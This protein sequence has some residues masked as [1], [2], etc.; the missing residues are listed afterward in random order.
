MSTTLL[1][2]PAA[3]MENRHGGW[4][5]NVY[6]WKQLEEIDKYLDCDFLCLFPD[7]LERNE[8]TLAFPGKRVLGISV[9]SASPLDIIR[10]IFKIKKQIISIIHSRN[11]KYVIL[12]EP[13]PINLLV[14]IIFMRRR[15]K[16]ITW[17]CGNHAASSLYNIRL[18]KNKTRKLRHFI[19]FLVTET[20]IK[21]LIKRTNLI[22]SDNPGYLK[23][24]IPALFAPSH[25]IDSHDLLQ[26][27]MAQVGVKPVISILFVGRVVP[28]K[29]VYE[30][31]SALAGIKN[32]QA[33]HLTIVGSLASAHHDGYELKIRELIQQAGLSHLV[34]LAGNI[35]DPKVL[36][37]YYLNADI[38]VLPSLTEGT[39]KVLLEAMSYGL[40]VVASRVGGIPAIVQDGIEGLLIPPRDQ[41]SLIKALLHLC[42]NRQLLASMGK[43]GRRRA[44]I[45]S[46]DII[47]Q[48][49]NDKIINIE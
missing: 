11:Y 5:S 41:G 10:D 47:F 18:S 16:I 21:Y 17:L 22:I 14:Y 12:F 29:G 24:K 33:V 38:F 28:L 1:S 45:F 9:R 44:K 42:Q 26:L 13:L 31:V 8:V 48:N 20:I 3:L 15:A 34:T 27:P 30:L 46:K 40:P 36:E 23:N 43:A 19:D 39:P 25:T 49:I 32:L 2:F 35:S 4:T 6:M 37:N 7:G